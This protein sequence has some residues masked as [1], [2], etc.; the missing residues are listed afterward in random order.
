[1]KPSYK[2]TVCACFAGYVVQAIVNNFVPLLFV[3]FAGTYSIPLS[4]I[5][6]LITVNFLIQ[7][8][9]DLASAVLIDKIGYR[10]SAVLAHAFAAVG[11]VMLTFLPDVLPDPYIGIILFKVNL[12]CNRLIPQA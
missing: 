9:I 8:C 7:L 5:T 1:M 10:A 4:K 12:S 3:T 6:L 11:L 2:K